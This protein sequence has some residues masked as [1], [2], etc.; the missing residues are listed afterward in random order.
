MLPGRNG[1]LVARPRSPDG[2]LG[3]GG[4]ES[5]RNPALRRAARE[6]TAIPG[7]GRLVGVGSGVPTSI[8]PDGALVQLEEHSDLSHCHEVV[9]HR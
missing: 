5:R 7:V 6:T 3:H 8:Q 9:G 2:D 4:S 1:Q